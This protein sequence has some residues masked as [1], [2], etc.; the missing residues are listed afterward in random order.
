MEGV[1]LDMNEVM[2]DFARGG[3][4]LK[5]QAIL[6]IFVSFL[7]TGVVKLAGYIFD[8]TKAQMLEFKN[9]QIQINKDFATKT[10][11]M[12]AH[13]DLISQTLANNISS[14][15]NRISSLETETKT[16]W[17][18]IVRQNLEVKSDI[19]EVSRNVTEL[20][21]ELTEHNASRR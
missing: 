2:K 12:Q 16:H 11:Q 5:Y 7:S 20:T 8:D 18:E 1:F 15:A 6:V 3:K 4:H 21:K 13:S 17:E 19:R 14:D 10:D 9:T